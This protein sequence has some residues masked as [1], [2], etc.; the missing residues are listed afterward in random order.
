MLNYQLALK[1]TDVPQGTYALV[2]LAKANDVAFLHGSG[3]L[4]YPVPQM[5]GT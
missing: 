4:H 5:S 3:W 1:R 2:L